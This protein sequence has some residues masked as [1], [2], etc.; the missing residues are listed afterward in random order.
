MNSTIWAKEAINP[1]DQEMVGHFFRMASANAKK[2]ESSDDDG[3]GVH[4]EGLADGGWTSIYRFET[5][6]LFI[7]MVYA[8]M[9]FVSLFSFLSSDG[10]CGCRALWAMS[11]TKTRCLSSCEECCCV[12]GPCFTWLG[13]VE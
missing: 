6:T 8:V 10:R 5:V 2:N 12:R 3:R 9:T 11:G 4:T 7:Q 13:I 1:L